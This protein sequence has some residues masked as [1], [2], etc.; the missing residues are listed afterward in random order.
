MSKSIIYDTIDLCA[1]YEPIFE[2][3][4]YLLALWSNLMN[5]DTE[6]FHFGK[7]KIKISEHFAPK[8][9]SLGSLLENVIKFS[10]N[11]SL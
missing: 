3:P 5:G 8:G 10:G 6:Y 2:P 9:K 7:T 1:C 4:A 11:S